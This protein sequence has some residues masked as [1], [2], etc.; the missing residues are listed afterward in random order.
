MNSTKHSRHAYIINAIAKRDKSFIQTTIL[1]SMIL[2]WSVLK[3]FLSQYS[4]RNQTKKTCAFCRASVLLIR[5]SSRKLMNTFNRDRNTSG[6]YIGWLVNTRMKTAWYLH[7]PPSCVYE[8]RE[9][10]SR[11]THT[12]PRLHI[13]E[14]LSVH[15]L[16]VNTS[17]S[18]CSQ[19]SYYYLELEHEF[20]PWC[21]SWMVAAA[22]FLATT[23]SSQLI[24]SIASGVTV[25]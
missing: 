15:L 10:L 17:G 18:R 20:Q 7:R 13:T 3:T 12:T 16:V 8:L 25:L 19:C 1:S 21:T 2:R 24:I 11:F 14:L 6:S 9:F 4:L 23:F 22:K 5:T